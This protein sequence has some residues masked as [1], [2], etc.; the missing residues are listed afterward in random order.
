M[1]ERTSV[2]VLFLSTLNGTRRYMTT[3]KM[4]VISFTFL[5][6]AV[7]HAGCMDAESDPEAARSMAEAEHTTEVAAS[8]SS[9]P[10]NLIQSIPVKSGSSTFGSLDIYF[11]SST[12]NNCA[13]TTATGSASGNATFIDVCLT[14]CKETSSGPNCTVDSIQCDPGAFHFFAGPVFE[15]APGQCISANGD[16]VFNGVQAFGDL[17]GASHCR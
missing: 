7:M 1:Q 16:I 12:G 4:M 2:G 11:D 9:C 14:R 3:I 10:G 8:G 6:T 17:P 13:K 15:H 5:V